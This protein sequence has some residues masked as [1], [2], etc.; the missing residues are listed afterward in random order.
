MQSYK[1]EAITLRGV[2]DG[3]RVMA[4]P[5]IIGAYAAVIEDVIRVQV[6]ALG[7]RNCF[8]AL[9]WR[10]DATRQALTMATWVAEQHP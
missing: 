6:T 4:G 3:S 10:C 2:H 1:I 5:D 9:S 7:V 8:A